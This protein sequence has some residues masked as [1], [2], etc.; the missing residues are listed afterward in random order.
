MEDKLAK[1][2]HYI[3]QFHVGT[4]VGLIQRRHFALSQSVVTTIF[5]FARLVLDA[6]SSQVTRD[7]S[8]TDEKADGVL[9]EVF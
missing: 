1:D 9:L 4:I 5:L 8:G 6:G 7:S 3:T 2:F